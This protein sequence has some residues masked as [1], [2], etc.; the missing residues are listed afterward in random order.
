MENSAVELQLHTKLTRNPDI[1]ASGI[2]DE[3]VMMDDKQGLYF[4][5]NPVARRIWEFLDIPRTYESLL[6]VLVESYQV[7][8]QKCRADVEPFLAKM[9]DHGLVR[10]V[11]E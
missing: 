1:F 8:S 9:L 2:D 7:D 6:N 10:I 3:M 5:L 4:G 11:P